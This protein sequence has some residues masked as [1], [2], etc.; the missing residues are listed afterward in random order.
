ME[1]M[2]MNNSENI[3]RQYLE[4]T[5]SHDIEKVRE[6][7]HPQYTYTGTDGQKREGLQAGIELAT[8]Y[9]NAFPDVK[10]E[11]NTIYT[12]G[13]VAI[14]EGI[15]QGTHMGK[16]LNIEPTNR[17]VVFPFCDVIVIRDNKIYSE[18]EYYDTAVIMQQLSTQKEQP[19]QA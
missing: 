13:D 8:M 10:T 2:M 18:Q 12:V 16:F 15:A 9:F 6:L 3:A 17:K 11:A 7:L 5:S 1:E 14:T 4:A 19:A